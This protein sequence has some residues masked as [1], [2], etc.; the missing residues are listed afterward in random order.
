M[1]TRPRR[2][3]LSLASPLTA[4]AGRPARRRVRPTPLLGALS[5]LVSVLTIASPSGA[6]H[7]PAADPIPGFD[8]ALVAGNQ[9]CS[10]VFPGTTELTL[11]APRIGDNDES[12]DGFSVDVDLYSVAPFLEL[13][14]FTATGGLVSGVIVKGGANDQIYDYLGTSAVDTDP[15]A[16]VAVAADHRLHAPLNTN[17]PSPSDFHDVSHISFCFVEAAEINITKLAAGGDAD[18]DFTFDAPGD[19]PAAAF[20]L[21]DAETEGFENLSPG[22]YV[23]TELAEAGF[24]LD[25]IDCN[26]DADIDVDLDSRTATI[27]VG[28]GE[29]VSCTFFNVA[30]QV[31]PD[32]GEINITKQADVGD[33]D[34]DFTF[35]PP[36]DAAPVGFI[37]NSGDIEPFEELLAGEYLI[38][39]LAEAGFDLDDIDCND[40]AD[41]DV[42][43]DA[44]TVTITLAEGEVVGCT[45]FNVAESS[46][47]LAEINITK[48]AD[49][50]DGVEFDFTFTPDG[51]LAVPFLLPAGQTEDFEDLG[52]GTYTV[53]EVAE[54]GFELVDLDCND[55]ATFDIDLDAG[56][57][58]I[59]LAA[60][61][62]VDCTFVNEAEAVV[63]PGGPNPG[64]TPNVDVDVAGVVIAD[65]DQP[66]AT[67]PASTSPDQQTQGAG[68]NAPLLIPAE[69]PR[70]GRGLQVLYVAAGALL[71]AGGLATMTG[72]RPRRRCTA[73]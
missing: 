30:A 68:D 39:E 38:T 2:W 23:V 57:V 34:F 6:N 55:E 48:L 32:T 37:L 61:E 12:E 28:A 46:P 9:K 72:R 42:D 26:D 56:T 69:L 62:V 71:V 49:D 70:T 73:A 18:F 51:K 7:G 54:A 27:T 36:R 65:Q 16:D 10:N 67:P 4:A 1:F 3:A 19:A 53:A 24:D 41:I 66:A 45:F 44:G 33:S 13:F 43:L 63:G 8:G 50:A 58:T 17:S 59:T 5:V 60:G 40:G 64:G 31:E 21:N 47:P 15:P 20:V 29:A 25:D 11:N 52:A 14:D 22:E 35:D